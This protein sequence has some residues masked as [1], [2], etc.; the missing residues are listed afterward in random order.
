MLLVSEAA[1]K[2]NAISGIV[3][4]LVEDCLGALE[5][6]RFSIVSR[7]EDRIKGSRHLKLVPHTA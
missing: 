5:D 6:D 2:V 3:G 4:L 1:A 7:R